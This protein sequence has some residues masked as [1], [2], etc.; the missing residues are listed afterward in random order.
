[1]TTEQRESR[2]LVM[3]RT[4]I[5]AGDVNAIRILRI[6]ATFIETNIKPPAWVVNAARAAIEQHAPTPYFE[7]RRQLTDEEALAWD[8]Q[9]ATVVASLTALR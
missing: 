4:L 6:H 7:S 1:M 2:A 5:D 9:I 3:A 8:A